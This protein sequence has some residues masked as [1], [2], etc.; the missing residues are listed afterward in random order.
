MHYMLLTL[1]LFVPFVAADG[2]EDF[3]NNLATDLAPLITLFGEKL[4][5]QFLSESITVLDNVI[6]AL[7]PLG[8]LT[9]VVSV[10]RVCG[11]ASLRAFIGRAQEGPGDAEKELLP[12]VSES[13]A[14]I[15]NDAGISRVF[16]R[17]KIVEIVAWEQTDSKTGEKSMEIGTLREAL[18]KDAWYCKG[19][20]LDKNDI[21]GI[22]ELDIPNL[23]LNKG[24]KRKGQFWF[25]CAAGLGTVMQLGQLNLGVDLVYTL[26]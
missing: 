7:S 19:D 21:E 1:L 9:A 8:V 6:F 15:F 13:T 26:Y 10:I 17:P 11:G 22:P 2:W 18:L 23:S 3:T 24:I 25:Y 4:T 14:E 16:G 20:E 12:C 5:K